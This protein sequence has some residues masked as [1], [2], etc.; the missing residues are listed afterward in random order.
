MSDNGMQFCADNFRSFCN[1]LH[2]Q[3]RFT[4]V[5]HSQ[6]NRLTEVANRIILEGLK[7]TLHST[8]GAWVEELPCVLWSYRTT[9]HMNTKE[10]P[11][12]LT[13]GQDLVI[14]VEIRQTSH[15]VLRYSEDENGK[16]RVENLDFL[17]E[18]GEMTHIRL[19]VYKERVKRYFDK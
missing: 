7:K 10:T 8:K 12:R 19:V 13:F 6:T 5:K 15:R 11:S 16:L 9:I 2:I 14:P 17:Q 1:D 4:S 18:D 3:Q